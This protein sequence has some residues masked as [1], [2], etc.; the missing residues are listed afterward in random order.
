MNINDVFFF[1]LLS[2]H[3]LVSSPSQMSQVVP[4][5]WPR[6]LNLTPHAL[7]VYYYD[8]PIQP[9]IIA[10][11]GE[12][13]LKSYVP[14]TPPGTLLYYR[15]DG[16]LEATL[17]VIPAQVFDGLDTTSPGYKHLHDLTERDAI[18]VS[19]PVAHYLRERTDLTVRIYSPAT[20]PHSAVRYGD[21]EPTR[22][23]QIKGVKA[24]EFHERII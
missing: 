12:L 10:S 22:K 7:H 4:D 20:G 18:I 16:D 6:V 5:P 9:F 21:E 14:A 23:G 19:M 11:D 3:F 1:L 15:Q 24:L 8:P 2:I 17:P 13:R